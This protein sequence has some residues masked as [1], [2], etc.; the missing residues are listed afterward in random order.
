MH[1][2]EGLRS[3]AL[4][5]LCSGD[6]AVVP[7]LFSC[8]VSYALGCKK[9]CSFTCIGGPASKRVGVLLPHPIPQPV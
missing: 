7:S 3:G 6:E 1:L 8:S 9:Y 2:Q 5:R 4:G